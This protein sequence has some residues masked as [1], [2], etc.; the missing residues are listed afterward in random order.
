[1]NCKWASVL[2]PFALS[3]TPLTPNFAES[4]E[5]PLSNARDRQI[6]TVR[7]TERSEPHDMAF[8]IPGCDETV[9]ATIAGYS[10]S[11]MP[12][13]NLPM[14]ANMKRFLKYT[15]SE[16]KSPKNHFSIGCMKYG[17]VQATVTGEIQIATMPP[18]ATKDPRGFM[19]DSS[20]KFLGIYGWGHPVPFARH[21]LIIES[22]IEATARRAPRPK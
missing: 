9:L 20:G 15:N 22:V 18:G 17:D 12:A 16:Y 3:V 8:E 19:H 5:C 10:D 1:M 4:Q 21:R 2:A 7:G 13:S 11:D 14:D 6:L